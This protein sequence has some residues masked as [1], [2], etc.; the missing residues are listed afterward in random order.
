MSAIW[1]SD[2]YSFFNFIFMGS[3]FVLFHNKNIFSGL[4]LELQVNPGSIHS[5]LSELFYTFISILLYSNS[6]FDLKGKIQ[7]QI[8]SV[9]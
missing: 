9:N 5:K 3:D 2:L 8:C 7:I 1:T 6:D 4:E